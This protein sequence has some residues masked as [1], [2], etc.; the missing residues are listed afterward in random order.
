M[1][2]Y[3]NRDTNA[4]P[5]KTGK[6]ATALAPE[7][8]QLQKLQSLQ[9]QAN[10][11]TPNNTVHQLQTIAHTPANNKVVQRNP[12]SAIPENA[13]QDDVSDLFRR[14]LKDATENLENKAK[15]PKETPDEANQFQSD[16]DIWERTLHQDLSNSSLSEDQKRV[17][18]EQ[19]QV[20]KRDIISRAFLGINS[21]DNKPVEEALDKKIPLAALLSH[22][23]RHAYQSDDTATGEAFRHELM[24]GGNQKVKVE[25][26]HYANEGFSV[27]A[28]AGRG[29]GSR[30]TDPKK[31]V[32]EKGGPH[33]HA[34][35]YERQSSHEQHR[36]KKTGKI[37]EDKGDP[38]YMLGKVLLSI[39]S[40]GVNEL[41]P[42]AARKEAKKFASNNTDSLGMNIP[43][44]GVGNKAT[45]GDGE[46]HI[47]GTEGAMV[48]PKTKKVMKGKQHG[49]AYFKHN[50]DDKGTSTMVGYEGSAPTHESMFGSHGLL[51]MVPGFGNKQSLTGQDKGKNM[52]LSLGKGGMTSQITP[53]D[54]PG[55]KL[56]FKQFEAL[57]V[58]EHKEKANGLLS[59]LLK[60]T[61][62]KE[63]KAA[64]K[65]IEFTYDDVFN[66]SVSSETVEF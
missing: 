7:I 6:Y 47:I 42:T 37:K 17:H 41:L 62:D 54:L 25:R 18:M 16:I 24:F 31:R 63:R 13:A 8:P 35:F 56:V 28:I 60:A 59:N 49:H 51:S 57:D 38:K 2:S 40:V 66:P 19:L 12:L 44:G 5:L 55:L 36:D 20:I 21:K 58:P 53:D 32:G 61:D 10:N 9:E 27:N 23:D 26:G 39:I 4:K 30:A 3:K 64:I 22:G 48:D 1:H 50:K 11:S 15:K 29:T 65:M 43:L 34:G 14:K 33:V 45:H 52:G 46:S